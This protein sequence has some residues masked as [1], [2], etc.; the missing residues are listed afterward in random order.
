[1]GWEVDR[2]SGAGLDTG[3]T[4]RCRKN[5]SGLI[6]LER[7]EHYTA[8]HTA[9]R[10]RNQKENHLAANERELTRINTNENQNL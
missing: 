10:S 3:V 7:W 9:R 2:F 6:R 4:A 8:Q 1:M 5:S